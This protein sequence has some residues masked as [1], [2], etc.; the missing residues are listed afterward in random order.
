MDSLIFIA[1]AYAIGSVSSAIIV[2][3]LMGLPDPRTEG[4]LNPG[5]TNVL[6]IGGK[7]AAAI[8]LVGDFIKGVIPVAA[9]AAFH[10][11]D[12]AVGLVGIAAVL[13]HLFP[14]FFKFRGGKGVATA[15]GVTVAAY[16]P[17]GLMLAL[18]WLVVAKLFKISSLAAI[19]A[20]LAAPLYAAA[21]RLP[22][23][24]IAMI[25]VISLLVLWRHRTNIQ[26]L[27]AG[28]EGKIG[29]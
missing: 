5:A 10:Q 17:L 1:F 16:W 27:V 18:T 6:R 24:F 9:A 7:K 28:T 25:F 14:V 8:T 12:W 3:R 29:R 13:G 21:F 20:T 26:R 2:C 15:F 22:G 23:S 4:S 11:P 19:V